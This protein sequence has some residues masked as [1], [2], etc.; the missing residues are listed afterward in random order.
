MLMKPQIDCK[1]LIMDGK[2]N[3]AS[4]KHYQ[5]LVCFNRVLGIDRDNVEALYSKGVTL[6]S[7]FRYEDARY[8]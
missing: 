1:K 7:I 2:I 8:C 4:E 5:S 6:E 3:M